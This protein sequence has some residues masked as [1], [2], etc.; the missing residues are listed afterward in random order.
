M[1]CLAINPAL[2]EKKRGSLHIFETRID[3]EKYDE[4]KKPGES[5]GF[6]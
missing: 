1:A 2:Q 6:F 5:P 3:D 4:E